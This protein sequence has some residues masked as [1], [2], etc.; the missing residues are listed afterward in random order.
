MVG[1]EGVTCEEAPDFSP[2]E[3][4][5]SSNS[6]EDPGVLRFLCFSRIHLTLLN[7]REDFASGFCN[8]LSSKQKFPVVF[9]QVL[10]DVYRSWGEGIPNVGGLN[11][12]SLCSSK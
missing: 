9:G 11:P 3:D 6:P 8:R 2:P 1:A 10:I 12:F 5:S 4:D 7:P